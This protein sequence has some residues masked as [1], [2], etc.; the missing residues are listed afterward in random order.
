MSAMA[1]EHF[2]QALKELLDETF[3]HVHGFYLDK[4]TSLF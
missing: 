2:T 3:D 4:G 1:V